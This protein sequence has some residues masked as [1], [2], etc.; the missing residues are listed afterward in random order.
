[1]CVCVCVCVCLPVKEGVSECV[2]FPEGFLGVD[3]QS[4]ARDDTFILAV[5]H[6]DEAVGGRLGTDPHPREVLLQQVPGGAAQTQQR[7]V[8]LMSFIQRCFSVSV[9]QTATCP[10]RGTCWLRLSQ[11]LFL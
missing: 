5:H 9:T 10:L 4:V 6:S 7:S 8:D 1:M 11:G 2:E 3:H